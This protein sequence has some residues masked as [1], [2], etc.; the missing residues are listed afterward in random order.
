MVYMEQSVIYI[1]GPIFILVGLLL[2]LK[3][4][5][6]I[7]NYKKTHKKIKGTIIEYVEQTQPRSVEGCCLYET[8]YYPVYRY[9]YNGRVCE[10][11]SQIG[12]MRQD[13]KIGDTVTLFIDVI[14]NKI[15]E[16]KDTDSTIWISILCIIAGIIISGFIYY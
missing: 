16:K 4:S 15:Y 2:L 7:K 13:G 11:K 1:I 6:I 8:L 5:I 14:K 9:T 10:Y 12:R 3:S